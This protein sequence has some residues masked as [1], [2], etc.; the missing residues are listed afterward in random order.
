MISGSIA[1]VVVQFLFYM[2]A[3]PGRF[4]F[5]PRGCFVYCPFFTGPV[6]VSAGTAFIW[7]ILFPRDTSFTWY[8][9]LAFSTAKADAAAGA[10]GRQG[11]AVDEGGAKRMILAVND[12]SL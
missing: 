1:F 6:Q 4:I 9:D 12:A 8:T 11:I 2:I 5:L 7:V 10:V 3:P